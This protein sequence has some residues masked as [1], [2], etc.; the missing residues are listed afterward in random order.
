MYLEISNCPG[1]KRTKQKKKHNKTQHLR[2]TLQILIYE[3]HMNNVLCMDN[4]KYDS[5]IVICCHTNA[6]I[7]CLNWG[8]FQSEAELVPSPVLQ[9]LSSDISVSWCA[10]DLEISRDP[11]KCLFPGGA[12]WG[13]AELCCPTK[14]PSPCCRK[15]HLSC[16][17]W[18]KVQS[19]LRPEGVRK[20]LAPSRKWVIITPKSRSV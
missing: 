2:L 7:Y 20:Q 8:C 9:H 4:L 18:H 5:S 1:K 6:K 15:A 17:V 13:P 16:S 14:A 10:P 3:C 11:R 19:V 12:R